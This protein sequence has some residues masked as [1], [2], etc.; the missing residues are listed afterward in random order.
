[1]QSMMFILPQ[2]FYFEAGAFIISVVFLYKFNNKP[3]RWFII[4]LLLMVSVE[5]TG[6]YIRNKLGEV[7]TWL[8]N[9]SIPVEYLFYGFIIGSLCHTQRYRKIIF[10]SSLLFAIWA[11]GNLLFIQGFT[12][13]ATNNL[14]IGSILM[15]FFSGLGLVD[16]FNNDSHSSLLKNPLF[17][18][19]TG[20][21]FFNT[22]EFLYLFFFDVFLKNKWDKTANLFASINNK[23]IYVLYTCLSIAIICSKKSEKKVLQH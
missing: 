19:C 9:M 5:L 13:L 6:L 10:Y 1:M 7:N 18:I 16:L 15:I 17:W 22:G 23:L 11:I 12:N 3:L 2:Y 8:Y 4:F 21:L 20:V 14:K